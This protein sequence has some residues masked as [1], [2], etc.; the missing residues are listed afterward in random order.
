MAAGVLFYGVGGDG[1]RDP[2]RTP[3]IETYRFADDGV[4]PNS[5][6]PLVVYRGA[7]AA[8]NDRAGA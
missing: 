3:V 7:L 5:R 8:G 6:L 2:A 4:V 1:M